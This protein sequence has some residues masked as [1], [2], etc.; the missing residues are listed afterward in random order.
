MIQG[1]ASSLELL[2][3][4]GA[5]A[6]AVQRIKR[7]SKQMGELLNTLLL[8]ARE[9]SEKNSENIEPLN[10]ND[11]IDT[12]LGEYGSVFS[13]KGNSVDVRHK[14]SLVV[15]APESILSI[16]LGNVLGNAFSYTTYGKIEVVV[17]SGSV[18]ITDTGVGM[19]QAS[20][21]KAFKPFYRANPDG[22]FDQHQGLGLAIVRQSCTN[23][24]WDIHLASEK[25]RGTQV[26]ICLLY[27]SPSPRDRG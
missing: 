24:G 5:P 2:E 13:D 23:Y 18:T 8:L 9:E 12:L 20:V 11:L 4:D 17:D 14:Q 1:S 27:T 26:T 19:D 21:E 7:T 16:V 10:V 15:R 22:G 3:L 6:R 25:G